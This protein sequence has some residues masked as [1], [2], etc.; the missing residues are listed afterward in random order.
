MSV[1]AAEATASSSPILTM[2]I[3]CEIGFWVLV[4]GGLTVRYLLRLRRTSTVLLSLLPILDVVLLIVVAIDIHNGGEVGSAHRL[5]GIYLGWTVMFAHSTVQALD[6]RFAH[7]FAGGPPP[8]K[9]PKSGPEAFAYEMRA[10]LKWLCAAG[11]ALAV[12]FGLAGTVADPEQAAQLR[13]TV[14]PVGIITVGWLLFGPLW[15][16]SRNDSGADSTPRSGHR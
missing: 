4:L 2:I 11:I 10:W 3:A 15:V 14:M 8:V 1:T 5:V 13:Q 7:K 6:I 12:T 9:R 16:N